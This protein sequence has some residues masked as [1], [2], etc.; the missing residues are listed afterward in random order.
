MVISEWLTQ[1]WFPI[2]TQLFVDYPIL[3]QH[4]KFT[5]KLLPLHENKSCPMFPKL[6]LLAIRLSRKQWE[7]ETFQRKLIT[8]S[9]SFGETQQHLDM[10]LHSE[11][12]KIR[13]F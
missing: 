1:N 7:I 13:M 12:G 6:Q 11:S 4:M 2:M 5:L 8:S 10:K 9:V 3:F